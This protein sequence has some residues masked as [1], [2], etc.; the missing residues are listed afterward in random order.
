MTASLFPCRIRTAPLLFADSR[1]LV[2]AGFDS[3]AR[4]L[5]AGLSDNP[6][7]LQAFIREDKPQL[8]DQ[9]TDDDLAEAE[10]MLA[11]VEA[12]AMQLMHWRTYYELDERYRAWVDRY[13]SALSP[14]QHNIWSY[15]S[16]LFV[17]PLLSNVFVLVCAALQYSGR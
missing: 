10:T 11:E 13:V 8:D 17:Q 4:A 6:Q 2:P 15:A 9:M 16:P 1:L 5:V 7:G 14:R 3:R 12:G